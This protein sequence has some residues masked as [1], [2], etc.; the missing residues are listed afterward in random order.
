MRPVLQNMLAQ[1][2]GGAEDVLFIKKD[3]LRELLLELQGMCVPAG[4][5]V[6][7]E[8][9]VICKPNRAGAGFTLSVDSAGGAGTADVPF[10]MSW[11]DTQF[12]AYADTWSIDAPP[13]G[14]DG[15]YWKGPRLVSRPTTPHFL[16]YTDSDGDT[17]DI[18]TA[19]FAFFTRQMTFTSSGRLSAISAEFMYTFPVVHTYVP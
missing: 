9:P 5:F 3:T 16:T 14:T 2:N 10:Q 1:V 17:L 13:G 12:S 18:Q 6:Q 19:N 7:D 15:V 11:S 8:T 4:A